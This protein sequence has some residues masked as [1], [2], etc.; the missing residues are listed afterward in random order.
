MRRVLAFG[1]AVL[2]APKTV[3]IID[4]ENVAS[5]NVAQKCG[6]REFAQTTYHDHATILLERR[7]PA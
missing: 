2:G 4:P 1:D 6:Y 5:L 7:R 3:C